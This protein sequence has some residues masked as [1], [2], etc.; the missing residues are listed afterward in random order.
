MDSLTARYLARELDARWRGRRVTGSRFDR[1]GRA[2]VVAVDGSGVCF[3]LSAPDVTVRV[4]E[5]AP[6]DGLLRGWTVR[7]VH[8]PED[9]RR[10]VVELARPGRFKGS[11]ERRAILEVSTVP[12]ARG[13]VLRDVGGARL[14]V[15]GARLPPAATPRPPLANELLEAALRSG[16][17]DSLLI[18]RWMSPTIAR[19][20][21]SEPDRARERYQM[22]LDGAPPRPA[23][24]RGRVLPFPMC[25]GAELVASLIDDSPSGGGAIAADRAPAGVASRAER[26]R[27]RM[28]GELERARE[29]P[30]L[31]MI[32]DSLVPLGDAPAPAELRLPDGTL[33]AAG[34]R[35]GESALE[36]AERL[37]REVRSMERALELLP[38]RLAAL[39]RA[40]DDEARTP[41]A[42][43]SP[44]RRGEAPPARPYRTY[45]SSGGLE[46]WVGRGAASNDELTFRAAAPDD[47]WLHARDATGAHVVLRWRRPEPPPARDLEE[48]ALLAAQHSRARNSTLVPVDWTRRKYVRKPRG[49]PPGQVAV[50]RCQTIMVRTR[51]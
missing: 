24:C 46:I 39:A 9:D 47:V 12:V 11:A 18:G 30:R 36:L 14:A 43:S 15:I 4:E 25:E 26:A 28:E 45:K 2:L 40:G 51:G 34:A 33:V 16:D 20:L 8:A 38:E 21:L 50:Q 7:G 49:A 27:R 13:A 10:L 29:A 42:T 1:E 41:P 17:A 35:P 23:R 5:P 6:A 37:Y 44:R 31:R 48:A 19:W 32:A 3:D 22:L